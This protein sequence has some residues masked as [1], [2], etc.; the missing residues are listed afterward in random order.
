MVSFLRFLTMGLYLFLMG[1]RRNKLW[2][3]SAVVLGLTLY[4]YRAAWV[5]LPP[6]LVFLVL[7]YHRELFKGWRLALPSFAILLLLGVPILSHISSDTRDR[8]EQT[9][10]VRLELGNWGTVK[11]LGEWDTIK[12]FAGQ[13]K[14]LLVLF[15]LAGALSNQ[16]PISS[17]TILGSVTSA[18]I[19]AYGLALLVGSLRR[20]RPP[21]GVAT[22]AVA[23][24]AVGV[25]AGTAFASYLNR[26]HDEYPKLAAGFWGW[27]SGPREII[28]HFVSVED[29]YDQLVMDAQFN[30]ADMFLRFYAPDGCKKCV[31][32][33]VSRYD[34]AKKQLFAL[35]PTNLS[36]RYTYR[37]VGSIEYLNGEQAFSLVEI[38]GLRQADPEP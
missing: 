28:Q 14:S 4:T 26:Y 36:D 15:P 29:E 32:G 18:L 12:T 8:S 2:L 7:L 13:Y 21:Y 5:V 30:G 27:Q 23:L 33:F 6:L 35:R 1:A 16:S 9:A 20:L 31:T 34:P 38:T 11:G 19:A 10:I 25:L 37:T 3:L 24:V 17:R 22:V